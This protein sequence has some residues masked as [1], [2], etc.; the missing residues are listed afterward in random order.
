LVIS[1]MGG[2]D[3]EGA[4]WQPRSLRER[5]LTPLALRRSAL[6]L[7]WSRNLA[8]VVAPLL[9][10]G[11]KPEILVGGIDLVHFRRVEH[12]TALR[13][14]LGVEPGDFLMLSPRLF[15]PRCNIDIIVR[16][17]PAVLAA[18]PCARLL[19][20]KHRA[21]AY[22]AYEQKIEHL[23]DELNVRHAVRAVPGI[24][25]AKMPLYYS[26][27]N[28]TVSIP[29][30]DG[31]PMTVM[32]SA[33]CGTPSIILDL[34]DYDPEVFVHRRSVLRLERPEPGA[35]ADAILTL[36]ADRHLHDAISANGCAMA[37]RHA[38]YA[39]EMARLESIYRALA[40][41]EE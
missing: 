7:C 16:A 23:L 5:V 6:V 21:D 26:A 11:K 15:W 13:R 27:A 30:T 29:A 25:N 35:L 39:G 14:S 40:V 38:D 8:G 22:P 3:I 19:L 4:E 9:H 18:L 12:T 17:L 33:A 28:C 24:P 41:D 31:T 1:V 32:E 34:P 20:V 2:G 37:K 10:E 36:A